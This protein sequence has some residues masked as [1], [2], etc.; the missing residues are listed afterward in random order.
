MIREGGIQSMMDIA[1][2]HGRKATDKE[3][4]KAIDKAVWRKMPGTYRG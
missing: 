2:S 4:S 1:E 3:C